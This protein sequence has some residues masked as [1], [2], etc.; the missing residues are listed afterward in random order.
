MTT[1]GKPRVCANC[2]Y[3]CYDSY[4]PKCGQKTD[5]DRLTIKSMLHNLATAV[6]GGESG[7]WH[8]LF[9]LFTHPERLIADYIDGKRK[10]YFSP[11]P[12]LFL[13]LAVCLI[14]LQTANSDL[15]LQIEHFD[16]DT[17]EMRGEEKAIHVLQQ[18]KMVYQTF[19]QHFTLI[20]LLFAPVFVAGIRLCFGSAFR[21]RYNWAETLVLQVYLLVQ[22]AIC[23]SLLAILTCFVPEARNYFWILPIL[24]ALFL[25]WDSR[26]MSNAPTL[27]LC[28]RSALTVAFTLLVQLFIVAAVLTVIF[29][30]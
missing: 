24:C 16:T 30:D 15:T 29:L 5:V 12:L 23:A 8:T 14:A 28:G 20:T 13:A 9:M 18:A 21:K 25:A 27:R 10:N 19:F 1:D 7:L 6:I 26:T 17:I 11:F 4:C 22:V 2:G 3:L